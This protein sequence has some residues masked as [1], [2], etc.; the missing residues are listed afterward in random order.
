[1]FST[2]SLRLLAETV[3]LPVNSPASKHTRSFSRLFV[4]ALAFFAAI[5]PA[6]SQPILNPQEQA[7]A[8]K[9]ITDSNQG[10]PFLTLD[11]TLVQVARARA[12]DL[13]VRDY[14]S[15]VN[16]DGVGPNYLV[17]QA[18]YQL[19]A[20]WGTDPAANNIE[21][22]AAG[23]STADATW[24]QWMN[25]PDHRTHILG[26]NSFY[27]TETSYGIGYYYDATSTYRYYWVIIT[28]PPQPVAAIAITAPAVNAT[29]VTP[30]LSLTGTTL[31]TS[32]ATLVEFRLENANGITGYQ[33][34]SGT[35]AWSANVI[36]LA[37]GVNT[38]RVHSKNVSGAV[39]AEITRT[40]TY[41][42]VTT[43][44]VTVDGSGSVT[45]GFAGTTRRIAGHPLTIS[46]APAPGFILAGW[47]GDVTSNNATIAFTI[48]GTM[49]L[50]AHFIANPFVPLRG[51]YNGLIGG[52][53]HTGLLRVALTPS[54]VATGRLVFDGIGY[55]FVSRFGANGTASLLIP[56]LGN[57]PL[58][59]TLSLDLTGGTQEITGTI[60]DDVS[61]A[62]IAADRN[63][64]NALTNRAPQAG[65]YTAVLA[66][67]ANN[68]NSP[69]GNGY[70]A[71]NV[72]ANGVA[73]I[74][75][76]LADGTLFSATGTLSKDGALPLYL[77]MLRAPAGSV[78]MGT[79]TF[80][81]TDVSDLDGA[82]VWKKAA[83]PTDA[84]YS[85]GFTANLSAVG[86]R[87]VAPALGRRVL[88]PS[89]ASATAAL[90]DGNLSQPISVP[91]TLTA[92]NRVVMS[93]PG[94]PSLSATINRANG[95][96]IGTFLHPSN[97]QARAVRG[98]VLQKQN[99]AFGFFAGIN[100]SGYFSLEST[101]GN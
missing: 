82:I 16:P 30:N 79:I 68:A 87:Y 31:S 21:S 62:N 33:S 40:V 58:S 37:P 69:Q 47:T 60:S 91:T 1:M 19:P 53:G 54:G 25:S 94:V 73:I 50:T 71:V 100:Q 34:A 44:T 3:A 11:P 42:Q 39:I 5:A 90:A 72:A 28:A 86:S 88:N 9:M 75:G 18:G 56:R 7:I 10:R 51:S 24:T 22:I 43:L 99:A 45:P 98:V 74:T 6:L 13:A 77:N 48:R 20:W 12:R 95:I 63:V 36:G 89:Q 49:N 55:S 97:H 76:Q 23:Y 26:L 59:V 83:R 27:A 14:F 92:T 29:V 46:A 52:N 15:H 2:S 80:H 8:Q 93:V 70:A 81:V 67:D 38:I 85:D 61:T 4:A 64:F 65:R 96:V 84:L 35:T 41:V 78:A 32:G 17:R 57:T 66:P 101:S